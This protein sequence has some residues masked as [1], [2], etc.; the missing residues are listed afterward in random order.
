MRYVT[1]CATTPPASD[2]QTRHCPGALAVQDVDEALTYYYLPEAS[3]RVAMGVLDELERAY[4][5][6]SRFAETGSNRCAFELNLPGLRAWPMGSYQY[7]IFYMLATD[8]VDIW[9]VLNA[10][11]DIP[12]W[13]SGTN[14]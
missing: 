6:L 13:L 9:R 8:H 12:S 4:A 7:V 1:E 2:P 3:D 10:K 5:H 14:S 11:R